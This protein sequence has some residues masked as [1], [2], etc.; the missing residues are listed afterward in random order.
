MCP[1][2]NFQVD[3]DATAYIRFTPNSAVRETDYANE[4]YNPPVDE[5]D[6]NNYIPPPGNLTAFRHWYYN[7]DK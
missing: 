7:P 5:D 3:P 6:L 1:T 4:I 2:L